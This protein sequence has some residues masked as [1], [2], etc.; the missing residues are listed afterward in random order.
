MH[1][2]Q[3]AATEES[4]DEY[5]V[6]VKRLV[7]YG[8]GTVDE[9]SGLVQVPCQSIHKAAPEQYTKIRLRG[10]VSGIPCEE[11]IVTNTAMC[12]GSAV[13]TRSSFVRARQ[14]GK[15]LFPSSSQLKTRHALLK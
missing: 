1:Q 10:G 4:Y 6:S 13:Y 9:A 11:I 14:P 3:I 5:L 7:A 12:Q 8:E 2:R 15:Y